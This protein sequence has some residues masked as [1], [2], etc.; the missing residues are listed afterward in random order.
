MGEVLLLPGGRPVAVISL[1]LYLS[2]S[3][4][5]V[6]PLSLSVSVSVYPSACL[7][8]SLSLLG[9]KP[10]RG[11]GHVPGEFEHQILPV[12]CLTMG[13]V[14]HSVPHNSS[15]LNAVYWTPAQHISL[16]ARSTKLRGASLIRNTHPPRTTI[17]P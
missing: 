15:S 16:G 6:L 5:L 12:A 9:G 2:F 4:H 17:G 7:F 11:G 14:W 13:V 1:S 8:V 10:G 3:P